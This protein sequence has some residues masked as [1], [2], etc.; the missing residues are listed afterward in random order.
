MTINTLV[1]VIMGERYKAASAN[2]ARNEVNSANETKPERTGGSAPKS[3][4]KRWL[5]EIQSSR[6]GS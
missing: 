2:L 6:Y 5:G 3:E 1:S 4:A